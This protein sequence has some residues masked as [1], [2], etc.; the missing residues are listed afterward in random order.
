MSVAEQVAWYDGPAVLAMGL[1]V[2]LFARLF[3]SGANDRGLL[4]P[5]PAGYEPLGPL[6]Q[7]MLCYYTP[8]H[9][10][11][12]LFRPYAAFFEVVGLLAMALGV[13]VVM[14][15]FIGWIAW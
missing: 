9:W 4:W 2:V 10:I 7:G 8:G 12:R 6:R 3:G 13:I 11:F 5:K 1:L 14:F 15:A